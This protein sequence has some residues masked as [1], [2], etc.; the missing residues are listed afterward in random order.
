MLRSKVI[1]L[2]NTTYLIIE[3]DDFH[4]SVTTAYRRLSE[5]GFFFLFVEFFILFYIF[6]WK[7]QPKVGCLAYFLT[8]PFPAG[9]FNKPY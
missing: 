4:L 3:K 8:I 6:C 5:N 9:L 7:L 2:Q 1:H